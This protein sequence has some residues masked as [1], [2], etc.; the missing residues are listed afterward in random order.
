MRFKL[1]GGD[2]LTCLTSIR[3]FG[4]FIKLCMKEYYILSIK[5]S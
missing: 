3:K 4:K 5:I 2:R 1:L